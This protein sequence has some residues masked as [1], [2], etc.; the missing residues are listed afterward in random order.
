MRKE[1]GIGGYIVSIE[2]GDDTWGLLGM[3]ARLIGTVL[4]VILSAPALVAVITEVTALI[5]LL[6][7]IG[8]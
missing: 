1:V 3:L 4:L 7:S 2:I 6:V 8:E 5:Y